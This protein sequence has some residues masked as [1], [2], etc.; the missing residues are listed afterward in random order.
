MSKSSFDDEPITKPPAASLPS[1][2]STSQAQELTSKILDFLSIASNEQL[3][4]CALGL[5]LATYF[6]L[7][8]L[9]LILIGIVGGIVLHATWDGN[10]AKDGSLPVEQS[11]RKEASLDIVK[12]LLDWQDIRKEST[13]V[14]TSSTEPLHLTE[15]NFDGFQPETAEALSFIVERVIDDY[16]KYARAVRRVSE[17]K[18]DI[19]GGT[20]PY[21]LRRS[22]SHRPVVVP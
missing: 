3:G 22:R 8:R 20:H 18:F 19:D 4:A 17:A 12:R 5:G 14:I 7:G 10:N 13:S 6:I 16:V 1:H 11:R 9:G 15:L 21:F 2:K